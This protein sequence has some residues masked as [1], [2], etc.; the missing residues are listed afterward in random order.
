MLLNLLKKYGMESSDTV[1]TPMVEK[2]KPNED[3][4]GKAADPTHYRGMVGT[5]MYLTASRPDLIFVVCMCVWYQAKPTKKH[6]HAVKRIFKYLRGTI[7][8][9]LWYPKDSSIALTGYADAD[10]VGCQDTRRSTSRSMQLLGERLVSLSSKRHKSAAISSMKAEY[11]ALSGCCAKVLW[12]RSHL[13]DYGLGFNK[14]PMYCDNK[15]AIALCCNNVQHSRSK[16][17]DVRFH[18]IKEHVENG[19]IELY[20]VNTEYQLADIF[21]KALGRERIEFLINKLGM[22]SFTPDTLKQ[23]ADEPVNEVRAEVQ[24]F[25]KHATWLAI[26]SDSNPVI[27]LR[28]VYQKENLASQRELILGHGLLYDHAKACDY[29]ASQPLVITLQTQPVLPI[30]KLVYGHVGPEVTSSQD[31]KVKDREIQIMLVDDLKCSEHIFSIQSKSY[32]VLG[33]APVAIIDRQ[34]PFEYT[35]T[36]RS[37]DVVVLVLRVEKKMFVIEQRIPPA[38]AADSAANV[39]AKWNAV[40]DAHNELKSMFEKQAGVE[41]FDLIQTFH[42]CKQEEGKPVAAYVL[43]IKGYVDQLERLGYVLPQDL[44]VGLILNGLTKDFAGFVRNYNMH[45]MRKIIGEL[46]AMLIEYEKGLPKKAKTPQ[47]MMIKSDK[48]QKANKKS[49]K[50]KGKGKANGKGKDKQ[51]YIPKPKNPKPTAKE[52]PAKDD[53]CHHY[54]EVGH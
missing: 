3:T 51:V 27:I 48:I 21:T 34:L 20:F 50:A 52:H 30:Y 43:K 18:F 38:P 29:F 14:I 12:I 46:H 5:L 39:L 47:V 42:A 19:V 44:T 7:N 11:I 1:D 31:G 24:V 8:R 16:H 22:R 6:L 45:N 25:S 54:K 40:Y 4:Q 53:T 2:S 9:G 49:F 41:R 33:I 32:K 36:S 17:I 35:I 15:S 13:T 28:K 26:I 23:L 37:T 10:H